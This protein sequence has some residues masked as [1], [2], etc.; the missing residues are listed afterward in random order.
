VV[1]SSEYDNLNGFEAELVLPLGAGWEAPRLGI[2]RTCREHIPASYAI[3]ARSTGCREG[4]H[5]HPP[6][7]V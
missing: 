6:Q 2:G 4:F 3:Q 1:L 5:G 7:L